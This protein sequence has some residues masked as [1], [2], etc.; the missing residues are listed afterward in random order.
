MKILTRMFIQCICIYF[1]L[2]TYTSLNNSLPVPVLRNQ[3]VKVEVAKTRNELL[4]KQ[5]EKDLITLKAPKEKIPELTEAILVSHIQ[6]GINNKLITALAKTESNF[7]E[8]AIGP[9]NRTKI[10][11]KGIL[12]TPT[13]SNFTDVDMLHGVRILQQKLKET[14]GDISKA[15]ALYKGG[16]NPVAKKQ[17]KHVIEIYEN[18]MEK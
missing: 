13:S 8:Q 14:N 6:T 5:I 15:L 1:V 2:V 17:A 3:E 18:L 12:Q 10:R 16:N 9:K 11:Y 4:T 7:D